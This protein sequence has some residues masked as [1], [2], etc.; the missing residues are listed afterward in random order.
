MTS[1]TDIAGV[2][3]ASAGLIVILSISSCATTP[4]QTNPAI[5][6]AQR[7]PG[8]PIP[9]DLNG[10]SQASRQHESPAPL[11]V[12]AMHPRPSEA[13][14]AIEQALMAAYTNFHYEEVMVEAR[15]TLATDDVSLTV[16]AQVALLA[17]ASAY[18]L[19]DRTMALLW[20]EH[21]RFLDP[22]VH[23]DPLMFPD[24]VL[25]LFEET[26]NVE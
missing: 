15:H 4:L 20:F 25:T 1:M 2:A 19:G 16:R 17:G 18:L 9:P 5:H 8:T 12:E 24:A 11:T 26:Q 21:A 13:E 10:D 14:A 7:P 6:A 22:S 23:P 3:T